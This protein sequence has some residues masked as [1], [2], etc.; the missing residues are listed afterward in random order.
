MAV[1]LNITRYLARI[2]R[3]GEWQGIPDSFKITTERLQRAKR[4]LRPEV[5]FPA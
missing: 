2:M 5:T 4:A 1:I 3:T